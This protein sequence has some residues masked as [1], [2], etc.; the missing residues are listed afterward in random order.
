MTLDEAEHY[1]G[2]FIY[3]PAFLRGYMEPSR[4]CGNYLRQW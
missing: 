1:L 4:H 2:L 3:R